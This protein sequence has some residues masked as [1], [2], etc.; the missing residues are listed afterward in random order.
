MG[1]F[2]ELLGRAAGTREK[3]AGRLPADGRDAPA[4]QTQA[5]GLLTDGGAA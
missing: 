5:I 2:N 1:R 3:M 4:A